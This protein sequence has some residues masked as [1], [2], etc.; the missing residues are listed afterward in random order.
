MWTMCMLVITNAEEDT[1]TLETG[2]TGNSELLD[3]CICI[4]TQILQIIS[5]LNH[6]AISLDIHYTWYV[7]NTHDKMMTAMNKLMYSSIP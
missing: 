3:M 6:R 5:W 1:R 7:N 2:V 4:P